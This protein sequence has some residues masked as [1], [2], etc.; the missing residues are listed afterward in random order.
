MCKSKKK[1]KMA[2]ENVRLLNSNLNEN[3]RNFEAVADQIKKQ[4]QT[5]ECLK[6]RG[7]VRKFG[8]KTAVAGVN[9]TMYNG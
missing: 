2:P 5:N 9:L 4:E 6:V 3:P 8:P 7:L 1:I